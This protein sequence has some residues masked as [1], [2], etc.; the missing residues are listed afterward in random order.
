MTTTVEPERATLYF[1]NGSSDKIYQAVIEP[2]GNGFVVNFAYGRRGST[3]KTGAKTAEPVAYAVAQ[4]IYRKLIAEKQAKGYTPGANGTPYQQTD[5]ANRSTGIL[6]QLLNPIEADEAQRLLADPGWWAQEKVDGQRVLIRRV[7]ETVTGINRQGLV[8]A[9]PDSVARQAAVLGSQQWVMDGEAL[10]DR[11]VA[12]DLLECACVDLRSRPYAKR[13]AA[14]AAMISA[15]VHPAIGLIETATTTAAKNAM[16]TKLT[17]DNAEGIVL[18]R[19]TA[20]YTVGRPNACGDQLKWKFVATAS[21][22]V[23]GTNGDKRSIALLMLNDGRRVSVGNVTVPANQSIPDAGSVVE[24]RYL[25]AYAGGSL[26]QPVLLGIRDDLSQSDCRL[27]QLKY[28]CED[29]S[30]SE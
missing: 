11:F 18:K 10:G 2:K 23:A 24:V 22:L 6:P 16:R 25:Y 5:R 14:L 20:P 9:L 19:H 21:C 7:G 29:L 30:P 17:A 1:K 12:F 3:L 13:L 8:V 28:R 26:Y 4:K 27:A 15:S